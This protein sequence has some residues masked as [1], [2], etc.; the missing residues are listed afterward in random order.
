MSAALSAPCEQ[1]IAARR[2]DAERR[3]RKAWHQLNRSEQRRA[4]WQLD[5]LGLEGELAL[6]VRLDGG[7]WLELALDETAAESGIRQVTYHVADTTGHAARVVIPPTCPALW[8]AARH[9]L[10]RAMC[11]L[12]AQRQRTAV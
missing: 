2:A 1:R 4:Y 11:I 5:L 12:D 8:W 3:F 6:C 7:D 10:G 9:Y